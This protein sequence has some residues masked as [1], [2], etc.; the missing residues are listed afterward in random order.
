MTSNK[1]SEVHLHGYDIEKEVQPGKT[2][3]IRFKADIEGVFALEDHDSDA[4]L[5]KCGGQRRSD[6]PDRPRHRAAGRPADHARAVPVRL[7]RGAGGLVR[8]A[9]GAVAPA[10]ARAVPVAAAPLVPRAG[11]SPAGRSR[12]CAGRSA[13]VCCSSS[14]TPGFKGQ[15]T[16]RLELRAHVRLRDLLG[17]PGRGEHP[18]RRRLPS[19]QPLAG[20]RAGAWPSSRD[21]PRE[22]TCLR[23]W[24]TRSEWATGL[25][26]RACSP[27]PPSSWSTRPPT[28]RPRSRSRRSSTRWRPSS[29]WPC[30]GSTRGQT[31]ARRSRSTSASSRGYRRSRTGTAS[32]AC[33]RRSRA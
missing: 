3:T 32:S 9:G 6:P 18:V 26:S 2:T 30:T 28:T 10:A 29:G 33:A 13:S 16:G 17:G 25:P 19:V 5:A 23:R 27:S 20:H 7:G 24:S 4:R 14:C 1:P 21:W 8:G 22:A 12:S 11:C 31:A 15:Q